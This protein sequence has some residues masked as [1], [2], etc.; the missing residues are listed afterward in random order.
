MS[1]GG[2]YS[3]AVCTAA[4]FLPADGCP[5][6]RNGAVRPGV[7]GGP[8]LTGERG[9]GGLWSP[10]PP[11]WRSL[12]RKMTTTVGFRVW[13]TVQNHGSITHQLCGPRFFFTCETGVQTSLGRMWQHIVPHSYLLDACR[14]PG[15]VLRVGAAIR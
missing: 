6:P 1:E 8:C 10:S 9:A 11:L 14:V 13:V 3:E 15:T 5:G 2:S 4:A 12:K 7:A